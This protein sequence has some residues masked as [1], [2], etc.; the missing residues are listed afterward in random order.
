MTEAELAALFAAFLSEQDVPAAPI[1]LP[2]GVAKDIALG[3]D[4]FD[5]RDVSGDFAEDAEAAVRDAVWLL[6][7]RRGEFRQ[8]PQAG[9]GIGD[10]LN[11]PATG[12]SQEIRLQL[13]AD[14]IT[15]I[16]LV[17]NGNLIGDIELKRNLII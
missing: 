7:A 4:N 17:L 6:Q 16:R 14:G 3:A 8:F 11:G 1:G 13:Q 10:Y 2:F 9:V 15:L 5:I 12:L